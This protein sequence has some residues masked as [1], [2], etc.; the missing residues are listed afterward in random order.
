MLDVAVVV[1]RS[2]VPL[3]YVRCRQDGMLTLRYAIVWYAA[4]MRLRHRRATLCEPASQKHGTRAGNYGPQVTVSHDSP[5]PLMHT[6]CDP[7]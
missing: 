2:T 7:G 5:H 4:S 3:L 1:P 6:S